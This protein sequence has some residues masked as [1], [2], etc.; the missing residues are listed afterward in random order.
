[1]HL[2]SKASQVEQLLDA[3]Q[4]SNPPATIVLVRVEE[5]YF[6][7][8]SH[9]GYAAI[10]TSR[11]CESTHLTFAHTADKLHGLGLLKH[12]NYLKRRRRFD[13]ALTVA[14]FDRLLPAIIKAALDSGTDD[15]VM[16]S[17]ETDDL[18]RLALVCLS[19]SKDCLSNNA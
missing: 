13:C 12:L 5:T 3:R 18:E 10:R 8:T 6:E 11:D 7:D 15:Y 17:L 1:M 9:A 16:Q 2:C 19:V 14:C 4:L